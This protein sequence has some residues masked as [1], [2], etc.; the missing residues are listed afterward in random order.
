M[1]RAEWGEVCTRV[2]VLWPQRAWPDATAAL[3]FAE[4]RSFV[5]DDVLAV[6]G[7]FSREGREWP[8]TAGQLRSHLVD[9][10]LDM[11]DF[12]E[13]QRLVNR[14]LADGYGGPY[15]GLSGSRE[16]C[17]ATLA[18]FP[19]QVRAFLDAY[20][21]QELYATMLDSHNG[22]ARLRMAWE[23]YVKRCQKDAA[24]VGLPG[25]LKAIQRVHS[26]PKRIGVALRKALP[27]S[28]DPQ[29]ER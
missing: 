15:F 19:E 10:D 27:A 24:L 22:P 20:G 21:A 2:S 9:L 25:S 12:L 4:L 29:D 26:D 13:V 23:Q 6:V 14:L 3:Y 5:C 8:P 18:Q 16:R 7:L 11:P 17:G 28:S 1:T